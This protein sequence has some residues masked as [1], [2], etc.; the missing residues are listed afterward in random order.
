MRKASINFSH[1]QNR[2]SVTHSTLTSFHI[3][4]QIFSLFESFSRTEKGNSRQL[5]F[6]S[7]QCILCKPALSH[8]VLYLYEQ[9]FSRPVLWQRWTGSSTIRVPLLFYRNL[10]LQCPQKENL[11]EQ[12]LL[13]KVGMCIFIKLI[14]K[15]FL[16]SIFSG[17]TY[18]KIVISLP[19]SCMSF[20]ISLTK[21]M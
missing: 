14:N 5:E 1:I 7:L 19:S 9:V 11:K 3:F 10:H 21:L 16:G 17:S 20:H 8:I 13:K 12:Q 15:T 6:N 2:V 4:Q 18:S